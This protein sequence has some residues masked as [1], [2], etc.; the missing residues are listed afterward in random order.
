MLQVSVILTYV[1]FNTI[2]HNGMDFKKIVPFPLFHHYFAK[3]SAVS[4]SAHL[5]MVFPFFAVSFFFYG[6]YRSSVSLQ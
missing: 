4:C 2:Y 1:S 5:V 3:D 6:N